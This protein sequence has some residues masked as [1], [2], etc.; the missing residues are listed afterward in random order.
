[1][2]LRDACRAPPAGGSA[3]CS[4]LVGPAVG[5][6]VSNYPSWQVACAAGKLPWVDRAACKQILQAPERCL[7]CCSTCGRC[8]GR[9]LPPRVARPRSWPWRPLRA[10]RAV[11]TPS[12]PRWESLPEGWAQRAGE[13]CR[14]VDEVGTVV[15]GS[16]GQDLFCCCKYRSWRQS[17]PHCTTVG[18]KLMCLSPIAME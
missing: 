2:N 18:S 12:Q 9:C 15:R 11:T 3:C 5:K 7:H 6:P 10:A 16:D 8:T 14:C 1:M 13:V 17:W 4:C